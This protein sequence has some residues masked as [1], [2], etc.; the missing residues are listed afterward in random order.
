MQYI[1]CCLTTQ[2]KETGLD[3]FV[4]KINNTLWSLLSFSSNEMQISKSLPYWIL[5]VCRRIYGIH[6]K[7][8]SMALYKVDFI[9]DQCGWKSEFP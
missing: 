9:M 7:N 1:I 2:Q 4:H 8:Q 5:V 3:S 6:W